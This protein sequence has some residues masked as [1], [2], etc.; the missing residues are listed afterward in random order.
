MSPAR[1]N[2]KIVDTFNDWLVSAFITAGQTR[3]MLLHDLRHDDG[4]K[5]FFQDVHELYVKVASRPLR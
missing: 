2:L 3:L 5:S 1:R 4:I